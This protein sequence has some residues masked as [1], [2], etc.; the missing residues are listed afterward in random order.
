MKI[1]T[2]KELKSSAKV[3]QTKRRQYSMH[4]ENVNWTVGIISDLLHIRLLLKA[5]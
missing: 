2:H 3:F 1:S 4:L 5:H